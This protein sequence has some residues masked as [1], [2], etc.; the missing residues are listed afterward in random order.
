M[1]R[2]R[3]G[4]L[5]AAPAAV[6][7]AAADP[8]PVCAD[9][10][11][12]APPLAEAEERPPP[13]VEQVQAEEGAPAAPG[14]FEVDEEAIER[15]LERALVQT[16]ALLLPAGAVEVEP[17]FTYVRRESDAPFLRREG[18]EI[19]DVEVNEIER[20][21]IEAR[22]ILRL[23]LPLGS[24]VELGVP[25]RYEQVSTV[26]RVGFAAGGERSQ[27]GTGLG[28]ISVAFATGLLREEGWRPDLI[29]RVRWD[30]DTGQTDDGVALG[31]GFHE[32]T[33]SLTAAKRQDPLVFVGTAS[34]TTAFEKDD[35]DPGDE[36]GLSLGTVLA[37]SPETSLRFFLA[38]T[39]VDD[40]EIGGREVEG[41]DQVS[42]SL[43]IGA[44]SVIAPRVV[45]D[46]TVGAGLTDDAPD[47]FI[48]VSLPIRFDLPVRF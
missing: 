5:I 45:L 30:S 3:R 2:L 37:A 8:Q 17:S 43:L 14:E 48:S 27:H 26:T 24:Q 16:G 32:I 35:I 6:A 33:G 23:G 25:F 34:Y 39:F 7:L 44:S 10:A 42:T 15:A 41:S 12:N 38:Q 22:A 46:V 31:S 28:D 1:F 18:R 29:G 47:Y 19:L 21:E 40:L 11:S 4:G 9:G 20:D 13:P 36:F